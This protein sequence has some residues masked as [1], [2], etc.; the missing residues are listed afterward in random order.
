MR[1]SRNRDPGHRLLPAVI[2]RGPHTQLS[3]AKRGAHGARWKRFSGE[4]FF[5]GGFLP[6][7][8]G[9]RE[10][11]LVAA[12]AR[13]ETSLFFESPHRLL[14]TLAFAQNIFRSASVAS[15]AS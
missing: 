7:K 9:G 3:R 1:A 14:K 11:D 15:R 2:A 4:N 5:F 13:A 8:S 6:P 12:V 10:R